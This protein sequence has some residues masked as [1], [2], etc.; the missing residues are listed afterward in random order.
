MVQFFKAPKKNS[1][2]TATGNTR[3]NAKR[4]LANQHTTELTLQGQVR[5]RDTSGV[6]VKGALP[7]EVIDASVV[8]QGAHSATAITKRVTTASPLRR[9]AHCPYA[10]GAAALAHAERA[11]GGCSW[12][13]CDPQDLLTLKQAPIQAHLAQRYG[14][15]DMV[16]LDPITSTAQYRRKI[17]L[18]V[19]ARDPQAIKVGFRRITGKQVVP[20]TNCVVCEPNLQRVLAP[21]LSAC[22]QWPWLKHVGHISIL[23]TEQ[24]VNIAFKAVRQLPCQAL[25]AMV[26]FAQEHEVQCLVSQKAVADETHWLSVEDYGLLE[27]DHSCLS[28][29]LTLRTVDDD[30]V[31][32]SMDAFVQVNADVNT[33]M[34]KQ[35]LAWLELSDE[36]IVL[37]LFAG[38]GNFSLPLARRAASVVAVEGV[39]SVVA[40]AQAS[41]RLQGLTNIQWLAGDL[42]SPTM[43]ERLS[44]LG[45]NKLLLDPARAGADFILQHL[46]LSGI[47]HVVYVSCH[48]HSWLRDSQYL[49]DAGLQLQQVRLLDMFRYTHHSELI[50]VWRR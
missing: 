11:C 44:D 7:N 20:I 46:D 37:D 1:K 26:D 35:A 41:A 38:A 42:S 27:A 45:A 25:E 10:L 21:L 17:R 30:T 50:S 9:E 31:V 36:D 22:Q 40:Q 39:E 4:V 24:G 28:P 18:A 19:D 8:E 33:Q 47:T 49:L 23:T 6:F 12:G 48:G 15:S 2:R 34:V 29:Q 3:G 5:L 43:A 13:F 14:I 32:T 16:W